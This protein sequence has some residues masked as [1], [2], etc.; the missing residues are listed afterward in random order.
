MAQ[1]SSRPFA[2]ERQRKIA[3]L[4][5]EHGSVRASELTD[6][7][8][9][10]DETIRR[11]LSRL[12]DMGIL[13]RAH[14]GA[15]AAPI[16]SESG[17]ARRLQ[18]QQEAKIA[19][20]HAA[21]DL[22]S[23][24][25]TIIIDS[26]TTTVH[27]A[28]ALRTKRDLVVI[29]NAVTNAIELMESTNVTVVLTGGVLRPATFG[30]VGDLAVA[31]IRELHVDQTFLAMNSVSLEGLTYPSFEEVAVKRA[32]IAAAS[33]VILLADSSKFGHDSLVRVAPLGVLSRIVTSPGIDPDLKAALVELGI[34]VIVAD[35]TANPT[36]QATSLA[37]MDASRYVDGELAAVPASSLPAS[38]LS[39]VPQASPLE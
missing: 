19:I 31:T 36:S 6:L 13:R 21:A 24:G 1:R 15:V 35:P 32:M 26:G 5:R 17:F 11:D 8:G 3:Q 33:E 27:L 16:R 7:F 39:R 9:V 2:L 28:R 30:A 29:T 22:V 38:Q 20:A 23:D 10:T 25:S 18:E 37:S 12:A 14:G 4:V 34:E